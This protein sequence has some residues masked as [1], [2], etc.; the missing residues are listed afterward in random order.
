M[1][2]ARLPIRV[3]LY[4]DGTDWVANC[5]EFD[6][7]GHGA[8]KA[9]ALESLGQA[10]EI[11]IEATRDS[12]ILKNLVHPSPPEFFIMFAHGADVADGNLC[13]SGVSDFVEI[14]KPEMREYIGTEISTAFCYM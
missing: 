3:V 6:L 10:I 14:G 2:T 9:D 8:T 7:F 11:Q 12:Q 13:L 4:R 1:K 5:L